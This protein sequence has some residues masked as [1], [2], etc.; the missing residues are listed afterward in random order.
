MG[1]VVRGAS[2]PWGEMSLGR[3]VRGANCPWGK[4]S[5]GQNVCGA[6]CPW[7]EMSVGR[8][9][10][11]RV[12]VGRVFVGRVVLGRVVREPLPLLPHPPPVLANKRRRTCVY[13]ICTLQGR[14]FGHTQDND[15]AFRSKWC[16]VYAPPPPPHTAHSWQ[17]F[18]P[19]THGGGGGGSCKGV[20]G[21]ELKKWEI[22]VIFKNI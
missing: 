19:L 8:D 1:W 21:Q 18:Y 14:Q 22:L 3:N 4:M 11:G 15:S 7:G 5:V 9:V 17:L 16:S 6:K 20:S 12:V 13:G 2:C 10:V